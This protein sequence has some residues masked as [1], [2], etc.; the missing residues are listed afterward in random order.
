MFSSAISLY[1]LLPAE[2]LELFCTLSGCEAVNEEE[3]TAQLLGA[4]VH[5]PLAIA[6]AANTVRMYRTAMEDLL[7]PSHAI[8][9]YHEL[10]TE[11][12]SLDVLTATVELYLEAAVTDE[13]LRHVFDF[14]GSCDLTRPLPVSVIAR[15][16]AS[17]FYHV[18]SESLAPPPVDMAIQMQKLTGI[19]PKNASFWAQL[20]AML[21]F[22][23]NVPS[24]D[25]IAAVLATSEDPVSYLR[26]CPLLRFKAYQRAGFE[27]VQVHH[28]S[29]KRLPG[30]FTRYTVSRLNRDGLS[31][32]EATFNRSSWFR[33]YRTFDQEQALENVHRSLPGI[34]EP[35]VMTRD[36]FEKRSMPPITIGT[37]SSSTE[38]GV[39]YL[40]YQHLVSHSHRV[41][42]T[43][44]EEVKAA[45][46]DASDILTRRYLFPHLK[47]VASYPLLS[48]TDKLLCEYSQ[49]AIEA[50]LSVLSHQESVAKF[51]QVLKKQRSL[52]GNKNQVVARTLVDMGNLC[53]T[54]NDLSAA[55]SYL[56]SSLRIYESTSSK[57][58]TKM[59]PLEIGT[60]Y[61]SL[62]LVCS[63]LNEKQRSKVLLEQALAA[64]QTMS[65]EGVVS[66]RQRKLVSSSLTDVAHAYLSLGDVMMAKKY[67]DLSTMA[68]KNMYLEGHPESVRTLN[69]ASIVYSMLGDKPESSR[70]R[71][72][73]GKQQ[74]QLNARPLGT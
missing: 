43:L 72:E 4:L 26:D 15:H 46:H 69:V 7:T 58:A 22:G 35:G 68:H 31:S 54:V 3:G 56:E 10:L 59:F 29:H 21:P 28:S 40:E 12:S 66:K 39:D 1:R 73:A 70:L 11:H 20:K 65:S 2:G 53:Y 18:S 41:V 67:I 36:V 63:A 24:T 74:T 9:F 47:H 6:L 14:L 30:L 16:V 60:A 61:S 48:E 55:K 34:S 13:R 38:G 71:G 44:S 49:T 8:T 5:H 33:S 27:H 17:P 51:E 32:E 37:M 50:S 62:A 52:F 23:N 19:D 45:D 57:Q 64:Y 42:E 25:E